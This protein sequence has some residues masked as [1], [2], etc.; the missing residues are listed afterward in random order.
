MVTWEARPLAE[1][2][3]PMGSTVIGQED[4]DF[5]TIPEGTATDAFSGSTPP[6]VDS[7]LDRA[8]IGRT[9]ASA[10]NAGLAN[11]RTVPPL[12]DRG[13]QEVGA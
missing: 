7:G 5:E 12:P 13:R 4:A 8:E 9:L 3:R 11:P 10:R 2:G 1:F 6:S